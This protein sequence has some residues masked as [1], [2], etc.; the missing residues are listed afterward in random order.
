MKKYNI[1][2]KVRDKKYKRE[3]SIIESEGLYIFAYRVQFD[4]YT[5]LF[6]EHELEL[7]EE[8]KPICDL[9]IIEYPIKQNRL[10]ELITALNTLG[11]LGIELDVK[12]TVEIDGK[13]VEL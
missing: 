4:G 6:F 13:K 2:D 3:G 5:E 12:I 7:I 8:S 11:S 9:P 10:E 1:G